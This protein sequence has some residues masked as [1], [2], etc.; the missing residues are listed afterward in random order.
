MRLDLTH[1]AISDLAKTAHARLPHFV[2]EYLDSGTG[3]DHARDRNRA[4]LDA[5][6]L[7]PGILSGPIEPDLSVRLMGREYPLP[8]GVAPVGMSGLI[9]PGAEET[10]ARIA[11]KAGIPYCLSTV[12]AETPETVGKCVGDQG[13]FQLYPPGDPDIRR[14]MLDRAWTS[15]FHTLILTVD[16]AVAS[17]RERLRRVRLT[18]PMTLSPPVILQAA[19][20]PRWSLGMLARGIPRLRTLEN[21]ADIGKS[22]GGTAHVGYMLRTVPDWDYLAALRDQWQGRLVVKGILSPEPVARLRAAGIDALWVS[23]LALIHISAPTRPY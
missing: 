17:R 20:K 2:W 12:A 21:Y 3:D 16:V 13:W 15:G 6:C 22:L 5:V 9:W 10:I 11:A 4:A 7:T 19:R 1:P 8:F 18:N 23:N 14:D